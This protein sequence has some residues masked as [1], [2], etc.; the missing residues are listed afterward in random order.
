[1]AQVDHSVLLCLSQHACNINSVT[2]NLKCV[3]GMDQLVTSFKNTVGWSYAWKYKNHNIPHFSTSTIDDESYH[4]SWQSLS[5][6]TSGQRAVELHCGG[7]LYWDRQASWI[8]ST[9]GAIGLWI[10][11]MV[12]I[13]MISHRRVAKEHDGEHNKQSITNRASS[14]GCCNENNNEHEGLSASGVTTK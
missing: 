14:R 10:T 7:T 3:Y 5:L 13:R 12:R 2:W 9:P 8:Q 1:M 6:N 4:S 11:T